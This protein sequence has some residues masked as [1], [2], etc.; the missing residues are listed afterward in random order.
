MRKAT[1]F[2]LSFLCYHFFLLFGLPSHNF[3]FIF[4]LSLSTP[5]LDA[6]HYFSNITPGHVQEGECVT[7]AQSITPCSATSH[8]VLLFTLIYRDTFHL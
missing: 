4:S 6:A 1:I 7:D 8:L 3:T 5:Q 2:F